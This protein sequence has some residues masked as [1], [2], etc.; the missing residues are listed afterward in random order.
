MTASPLHDWKIPAELATQLEESAQRHGT[1]P[2]E[3]VEH[4]LAEFIR[5][6]RVAQLAKTQHTQPSAGFTTWRDA[7]SFETLTSLDP[8]I[9]VEETGQ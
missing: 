3:L 1:T 2:G 7:I 8:A 5:I 4:V 6:E 9:V